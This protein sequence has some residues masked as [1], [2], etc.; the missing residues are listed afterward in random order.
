MIYTYRA[1]KGLEDIIEGKIEASTEK[2]AIEKVSQLGLLPIRIVEELI[3]E[4]PSDGIKEPQRPSL[5]EVRGRVKSRAITVFSRQLASL[6]RSGVPILNALNV[7]REQSEN[8]RLEYILHNIHNEIKEGATFSSAL[9]KFPN[10]FSSLY[11]PMVRAGEDTGNLP[12]VLLRIADYRMKQEELLSRIR[13]SLAYPVLMAFVGLGTVVFMLTFVLPRLMGI[14][15]NL[16]EA[17]PLPTQILISISQG[18]RQR[19]FWI[20]LIL[21]MIV[22][23]IKR[24]AKTKTGKLFFSVFKL[25][26]PILGNFML[27][28]EL[29]RFSRT[30]ELLIKSGLP[31][32]KTFDIAIPVLGNEVIKNQLRESYKQLEQG[33]S[34]GRSLKDS[35]VFPPFMSNLITVGEESGKLDEALAEVAGSYERETD[36]AMRV[37]VSL[38]EPLM[39]LGMGL[40]VG[41]IVVAMLLP[42]FEINMI[43]K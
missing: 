38:L 17:L 30:L 6:L 27:K 37:M 28:A 9:A 12:E 33:G 43:A 3:A 19:W 13:M 14:F 42:I 35:K 20:V 2:E 11:I 18:L 36:E 21:A 26:I 10:I 34:F 4:E 5:G 15:V 23:I 22:L 32:L 39:I 8:P 31:I 16:G 40:V 24:H 29:S 1:K 7:I 25:H 41:F